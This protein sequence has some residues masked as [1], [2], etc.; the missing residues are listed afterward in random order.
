MLRIISFV[1]FVL[2]QG[3]TSAQDVL[4]NQRFK[5]VPDGKK[6]VLSADRPITIIVHE[7]TLVYGTLCNARV[8]SSPG[9]VS[10][11]ISQGGNSSKKLYGIVF[12]NISQGENKFTYAVT[13]LTIVNGDFKPSDLQSKK[14]NKLGVKEIIFY[15]GEKV[16][17]SECLQGIYISESRLTTTDISNKNEIDKRAEASLIAETR[18][19]KEFENQEK[20]EEEEKNKI[21]I[22]NSSRP[23]HFLETSNDDKIIVD[24]MFNN[25]MYNYIQKTKETNDAIRW[26]TLRSN[27]DFSN[28]TNITEEFKGPVRAFFN[29]SGLLYDIRIE[30]ERDY[31]RNVSIDGVDLDSLKNHIKLSTGSYIK[32]ENK[33]YP[34]DTYHVFGFE[35]VGLEMSDVMHIVIKRN[36]SIEVINERPKFSEKEIKVNVLESNEISRLGK[37]S[38]TVKVKKILVNIK[39]DLAPKSSSRKIR[40]EISVHEN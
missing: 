13:P 20:K 19:K 28:A 23:F 25:I 16:S 35:Y 6:W 11:I 31:R 21:E 29:K 32:L 39:H 8:K 34:V 26:N 27:K 3:I 33:N 5:I 37:G 4:I 7:G 9:I 24:T 18:S 12:E 22:R 36:K 2:S 17:V 10:I 15:P 38:Y 14:Y 30:T 1:I 40:Y